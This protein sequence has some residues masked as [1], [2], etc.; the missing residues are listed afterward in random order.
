MVFLLSAFGYVFHYFFID[1]PLGLTVDSRWAWYRFGLA[2][3]ALCGF[4]TTAFL[5]R[6]RPSLVRVPLAVFGSTAGV[7]QAWSMVWYSEVPYLYAIA[8]PAFTALLLRTSA[9]RSA[10]FLL[11][12]FLIQLPAFWLTSVEPHLLFSAFIV[13]V[14][15]VTVLRARSQPEEEQTTLYAPLKPERNVGRYTLRRP[16][17][18]GGMGEVWAAWHPALKREIALKIL[19]P[20]HAEPNAAA[21]FQREVAATS[22]L[23]HPNTV[24]VF[25]YGVADDGLLYYAMELLQGEDLSKLVARVGALPSERAVHLIRQAARALA[26]AHALGMIH[27]DMKPENLF[28]TFAGGESDFVKVLDFGIVLMGSS[29]EEEAAA[30]LTSHDVVLGTVRYMAPEAMRGAIA[31]PRTDVYGLGAALYFAVTGKG[32]FGWLDKIAH[33]SAVL[34]TEPVPRVE[35]AGVSSQLSDVIARALAKEPYE[36]YSDA[37]AFGSALELIP[38]GF[39]W[40]SSRGDTTNQSMSDKIGTANS[41]AAVTATSKLQK[42]T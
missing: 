9:F 18:F 6:T 17:G 41:P 15:V 32:P 19:R 2:A 13:T 24:R 7:V 20:R 8:I 38:E 12:T 35:M 34:S 30:R 25:D 42:K 22:V 40:T 36:R 29:P 1:E 23:T 11:V 37:A 28:V 27:R 33:I 5:S 14:V 26:E 21:R 31:T 4:V 39:R 16:L 10:V 3:A